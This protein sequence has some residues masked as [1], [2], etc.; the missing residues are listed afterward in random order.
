MFK[1]EVQEIVNKFKELYPDYPPLHL[2]PTN[3]EGLYFISNL[4]KEL[5][6]IHY[7]PKVYMRYF[8]IY[9]CLAS[10]YFCTQIKHIPEE[11]EKLKRT[12]HYFREACT[13]GTFELYFTEA[14]PRWLRPI[15]EINYNT[16]IRFKK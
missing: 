8:E 13:D 1:N 4:V 14:S 6:I 7:D 11:I 5:D 10:H 2:I 12:Q 15:T 3:V 9:G 16:Y